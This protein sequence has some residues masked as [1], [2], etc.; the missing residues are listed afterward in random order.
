MKA[1]VQL[2]KL[3]LQSDAF[4]NVNGF[5]TERTEKSRP[6][7]SQ[8]KTLYVRSKRQF[9]VTSSNVDRSSMYSLSKNNNT[10]GQQ[11]RREE[12]VVQWSSTSAEL[13]VYW[14]LAT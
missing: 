8:R 2:V 13:G 4:F 3:M 9:C 11:V 14:Q 1:Y 6:T 5:L 12:T 7:E 10:A